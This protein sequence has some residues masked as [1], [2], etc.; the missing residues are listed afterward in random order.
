MKTRSP[1]ETLAFDRWS[2]RTRR[3]DTSAH[4]PPDRTPNEENAVSTPEFKSEQYEF[5]AEQNRAFSNL[6]AAMDAVA[7]LLKIVGLVFLIFFGLLLIKAIETKTNYG[8]VAAIG[9]ATLL[10]LSIGFWT[11]S[12]AKSFRKIVESTNRDIWHL[13]NALGTLHSMYSLLRTLVIASLVL[14]AIGLVL[15]GYDH[16]VAP[17]GT[18]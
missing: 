16:F 12:S 17:S 5:N 4:R 10:C 6:A 11:A 14:L 9:S 7:G 18:V 1:G 8:P 13:M 2:E 15:Y 3:F